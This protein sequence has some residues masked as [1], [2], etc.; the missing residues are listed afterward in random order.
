MSRLVVLFTLIVTI[1]MTFSAMI[2]HAQATQVEAAV[3]DNTTATDCPECQAT[4]VIAA[5]LVINTDPVKTVTPADPA[6]HDLVPAVT[7]QNPGVKVPEILAP[8]LDPALTREYTIDEYIESIFTTDIFL[9]NP[10]PSNRL[11]SGNNRVIRLAWVSPPVFGYRIITDKG[12]GYVSCFK[13]NVWKACFRIVKQGRSDPIV[14]IHFGKWQK[15]GSRWIGVC[16]TGSRMRFN[17]VAISYSYDAVYDTTYRYALEIGAGA[18][19]AWAIARTA[20]PQIWIILQQ[21]PAYAP[22]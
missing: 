3:V 18:V 11:F 1:S 5:G 2:I 12:F 9:S 16:N 6:N 10:H 20:A 13:A 14:D 4:A 19:A 17:P 8:P 21:I 22:I 7:V 15:N